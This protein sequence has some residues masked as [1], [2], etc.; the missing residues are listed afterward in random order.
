MHKHVT[1]ESI[2]LTREI[3][4]GATAG[5]DPEE[6][7]KAWGQPS[8][9][10]WP[11]GMQSAPLDKV[12][13]ILVPIL[14]PLRN[15]IP[16]IPAEG[17]SQAWWKA[18]TGLNTTNVNLGLGDGNRGGIVTDATADYFA[19]YKQ[20]GLDNFVTRGAQYSAKG[21]IDLLSQAQTNL[22]WATMIAEESLDLWGNASMALGQGNQPTAADVSTGGAIPA[23]TAMSIKVV[24]LTL[25]GLQS[26]S[27]GGNIANP[28]IAGGLPGLVTRTNA[29]GTTDTYGGGSG[30][31]SAARTITT[32]NDGSAYHSVQT[33]TATIIGAAA[34]GWFWGATGAETLGAITTIN[35]LVITTAAGVGTQLASALAADNSKN[36]LV[37]DGILTTALNTG[38]GGYYLAMATG[39]AGVGTPLT[40]DSEGG[41]VEIDNALQ[42]FWDQKRVSPDIIWVNSQERKNISKKVLAGGS[43]GGAQRFVINTDQGNVTGGDVVTK[44]VNKFCMGGS[45]VLDIRIHPN[46]SPGTIAFDTLQIDWPT[47]NIGTPLVKEL[48]QEYMAEMYAPVSRK[49]SFGVSFD[50]VLKNVAPF[51]YGAICNIANG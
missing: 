33:T 31:P 42:S 17:G 50:G 26:A 47:Q 44:Y 34:Y 1:Q 32:A 37:Y 20:L 46:L 5:V 9:P 10:S 22:L 19:T 43:N 8:T 25:G 7:I 13:R 38:M 15:R 40:G 6:V 16:R 24:P 4:A 48:R 30:L 45:K 41:V 21:F 18:F 27:F 3:L 51:A 28:N 36:A 35:S 39:T 23:N 29:D 14:T 2:D 12:A 11:Q 49:Y